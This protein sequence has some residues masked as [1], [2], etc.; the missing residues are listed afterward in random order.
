MTTILRTMY[1]FFLLNCCISLFVILGMASITAQPLNNHLIFDGND[2]YISLNNMDVSGNAITL[3]ALI[4]SS[5]LSNCQYQ[6]CRIISKAVGLSTPDHYWMLS[7]N[8]SGANTVLRFRLKTNGNSTTLVAT[9]GALSENTWYH[10]AATYDGAMMRLFLDGTEVGSTAKTGTL[11]TNS[12]VGT[13]IG[14]NPPG[15]ENPWKGEI[16]EV[17]IWNT[18]RTQ[19][20]IQA[21]SSTE[22]TGNEVGLQAYYQF[23]EGSGQTIND[24]AGNNNTVLGSTNNSDSNDPSFVNNPNPRTTFNLQVFL[25]GAFDPTQTAM[26]GGLLQRQV[27][28]TGQPYSVSPWNY[29]GTEG[30]GWLPTDYPTETVDWVLVTLRA[31]LDPE[32]EVARVAAVLLKNGSISPFDVNLNGAS[33]PLHVMIEH[34]NHLPIIS[35]QP[36]PIVNGILSYDF[37]TQNSY[38]PSGFGQKQVGA[39]WMMYGGNSDQEGT[40]GCD[41]NAADRAFWETVNGQFSVYNPG[42]Y[43]LDGDIT[44][45]DKIVFNDNNGIFTTIPKSTNPEVI[46]NCPAPNFVLDTCSYTFSWTHPN[47]TSTT[48]NYDLIING[49][50][51][52]P[53]VSYPVNSNTVDIC[54]LLGITSGSGT[55]SGEIHYW[56]DGDVTNIDTIEICSINYDIAGSS[57]HGQ[58]KTFAQIAN[59][60]ESNFCDPDGDD[61]YV[62]EYLYQHPNVYYWNVV[63]LPNG[64]KCV[65]PEDVPTVPGNAIQLP[66]PSGGDDTQALESIINGNPGKNFVGT[67]GTYRLNALDVNVSAS[68]WNVPSRP[69]SSTTNDIWHINTSDIRIYNS[70]IDGNNSSGF[71]FGW[72]VFDGSDRFHLINSGLKDVRVKDGNSMCAVRLRAVDDFYIAGNTFTNLINNSGSSQTSRANAIWQSPSSGGPTS[73]GYIVNNSA[74]NFQSEGATKDSEFYTRQSFTS[75][76]QKVR[77][78]GNRCVDAGKRFV[79]FQSSDG[80]ILSNRAVWTEKKGNSGM[81]DRTLLAFVAIIT[82]A[83]RVSARNNRFK[84]EAATNGR[85]ERMCE[86]GPNITSTVNTTDGHI[87]CN[88]FTINSNDQGTVNNNPSVFYFKVK[89]AGVYGRYVQCSVKDNIINGS[90]AIEHH[91]DFSTWSLPSS[92]WPAGNMVLTGNQF[93]I[94]WTVAEYE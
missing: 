53:S 47:P 74:T 32:T 38:S 90:G 42:D 92:G 18:A 6:D 70:P 29:P 31:S 89:G 94:P 63:T 91:W 44:G 30:S 28:P 72:H 26:T 73:G 45:A 4:N 84:V 88:M 11:T 33:T 21:N 86:M 83:H 71:Q 40:N 56:F 48:V 85:L 20:Q 50:D 19:A 75:Q 68:I 3:E 76:G 36:I 35:A 17:R 10:V 25:E 1:N 39:N 2:D 15:I 34:R 81:P 24:Q 59:D 14:A 9:T 16:D 82:N 78:F 49:K 61:S 57:T 41:I 77:I 62:A 23:N 52:G 8:N 93:L 65:V 64:E 79:K 46:F 37:T 69:V 87:D 66:A 55:I 51:V 60:A 80:L 43:N 54:A 58:G 27:V 13:F 67:G 22:L 7:T 12:A 5:D